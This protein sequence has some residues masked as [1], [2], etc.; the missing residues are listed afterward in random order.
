M[1]TCLVTYGC[2][3]TAATV[4]SLVYLFRHLFCFAMAR[5]H[6]C[7]ECTHFR[8]S[9]RRRVCSHS[10]EMA[11]HVQWVAEQTVNRDRQVICSRNVANNPHIVSA[12]LSIKHCFLW[13][14]IIQHLST[15]D[16]CSVEDFWYRVEWQ[17]CGSGATVMGIDILKLARSLPVSL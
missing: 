8:D 7:S 11:A 4:M 15:L 10:E 1:C 16:N 2:V 9:D 13:E 5:K 14:T 17:S 6:Q 3:Y 12:Y